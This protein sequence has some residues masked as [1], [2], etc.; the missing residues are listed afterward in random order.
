[1]L[2]YTDM[3]FFGAKHLISLRIFIQTNPPPP[4]QPKKTP[5]TINT[6]VVHS[7]LVRYIPRILKP[8]DSFVWETEL[9][10]SHN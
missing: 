4:P 6:V 9:I 3:T 10:L 5:T 1:M 7:T 2:L 8:Y